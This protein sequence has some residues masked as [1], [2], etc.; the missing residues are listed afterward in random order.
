[1]PPD[2]KSKQ[3]WINHLSLNKLQLTGQNL[4]QVFNF[5]SGH[6]RAVTFLVL[7]GKVPNLQLKTRPKQLLG[8]IPLVIA[9]PD[10]SLYK[11]CRHLPL[12]PTS[13]LS[14]IS[15]RTAWPISLQTLQTHTPAPPPALA[16]APAPAPV[17]FFNDPSSLE[18]QSWESKFSNSFFELGFACWWASLMTITSLKSIRNFSSRVERFRDSSATF[19]EFSAKQK[20]LS[21]QWT[22]LDLVLR[23]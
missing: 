22:N 2:Q 6:L 3:S 11:H 15:Y 20:T 5:R 16:P 18:E 19:S 9:L 1:M 10:L 14:P 23:M 4:D 17:T 7:S 8:S 13:R 12:A 21:W